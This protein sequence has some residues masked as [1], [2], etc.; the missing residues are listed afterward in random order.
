MSTKPAIGID[1]GNTHSVVA[2]FRNG[3]AEII[4][5]DNGNRRTP[6]CVAFTEYERLVGESAVHQA[7]FNPMNTIYGMKNSSKHQILVQLPYFNRRKTFD[8]SR[9]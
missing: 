9:V 1:L 6:S 8:W 7:H 4:A 3:A 2:V 5:N